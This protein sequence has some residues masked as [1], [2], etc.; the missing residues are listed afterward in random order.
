MR[1]LAT[2]ERRH[3]QD[4]YESFGWELADEYGHILEAFKRLLTEPKILDKYQIPEDIKRA[5]L[6]NIEMRLTPQPVKVRTDFEVTCFSYAGIDAIKGALT[7]GMNCGTE[8]NPI[9]CR[10]IAPPLYVMTC[11]TLDQDFGIQLLQ[12]ALD[13]VK[14]GFPS[15]PSLQLRLDSCPTLLQKFPKPLFAAHMLMQWVA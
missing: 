3:V 9:T 4:L 2:T 5:L 13:K 12:G 6:K 1:N 14:V 8:I 15:L 10:L 7:A 11:N